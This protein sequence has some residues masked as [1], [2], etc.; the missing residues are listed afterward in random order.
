MFDIN[1]SNNQQLGTE[2]CWVHE[3][4]LLKQML[5]VLRTHGTH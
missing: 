1:Q 3:N 2:P 4:K 5:T